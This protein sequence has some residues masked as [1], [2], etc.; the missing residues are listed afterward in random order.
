MTTNFWGVDV[1]PL[2]GA[3]AGCYCSVLWLG[4]VT[5]NFAGVDV[6]PLQGAVVVCCGRRVTANFGGVVPLQC[7]VLFLD[8]IAVLGA[9]VGCYGRVPWVVF[10]F[11]VERRP[12]TFGIIRTHCQ[13][14]TGRPMSPKIGGKKMWREKNCLDLLADV[15]LF[16]TLITQKLVF[17]IWALCWYYFCFASFCGD[18]NRSRLWD[19]VCV[20]V[21]VMHLV[22]GYSF[23]GYFWWCTYSAFE[24]YCRG[25]WPL[26]SRSCPH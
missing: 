7:R 17:A 20:C 11:L 1:V 24:A 4:R 14:G 19:C 25:E 18:S 21:G 8:A 23:L 15:T 13:R 9:M 6:V 16:S 10:N 26:G 2:L 3:I 5:A 22:A 12:S